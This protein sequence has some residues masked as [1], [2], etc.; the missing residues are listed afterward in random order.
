MKGFTRRRLGILKGN[1]NEDILLTIPSESPIGTLTRKRD[2]RD[3]QN[4]IHN[5]KSPTSILSDLSFLN[6]KN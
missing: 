5:R 3:F 1:K 4:L 2:K 6:L